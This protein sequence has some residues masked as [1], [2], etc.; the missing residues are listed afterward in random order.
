MK[1]QT[2]IYSWLHKNLFLTLC[3]NELLLPFTQSNLTQ[4]FV[5]L[6][7]VWQN[8][9]YS[10]NW[11]YCVTTTGHISASCTY[12]VLMVFAD[13]PTLIHTNAYTHTHI[14]CNI[15]IICYTELL[16]NFVMVKIKYCVRSIWFIFT[17][18]TI[19]KPFRVQ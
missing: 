16:S 7:I 4:F 8:H 13:C 6:I 2:V 3:I 15:L 17:D 19:Q 1:G 9:T 14:T 10:T 11:I 5:T 12:T 18:A